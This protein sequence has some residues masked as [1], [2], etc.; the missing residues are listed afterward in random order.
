MSFILTQPSA[1]IN[2]KLTNKGRELLAQGA[3]TYDLFVFGD[4]EIDYSFG[5]GSYSPTNNKILAPKDNNPKIKYPISA[6]RNSNNIFNVLPPITPVEQNVVNTA[7]SRGFFTGITTANTSVFSAV[8]S[9]R[10]MVNPDGRIL[11]KDLSGGTTLKIL[12]ASTYSS[13]N[14]T[15]PRVGDYLFVGIRHPYMF[16]T[17][18][19]L[20]ATTDYKIFSAQTKGLIRTGET[21]PYLFY[22]IHSITSGSLSSGTLTVVVD[23]TL[24]NFSSQTTSSIFS[25][26]YFFPFT[27]GDSI[28]NFYGSGDTTS[29]WNNNTLSFESNCNVAN[30]DVLVWNM[31]IVSTEN[32]AGVNTSTYEGIVNYGSSAY[33][34]F[35][36]YISETS[37]KPEQFML[38]II[39]YT[40][41]SISNYYAEGFN[42]N[43]LRLTLPTI[44]WH[45][46]FGS[47][48]ALGNSIGLTLTS[49]TAFTTSF[50]S[51]TSTTIVT[52]VS[53]NDFVLPFNNL[54]D[55]N[56]NIV[57][58]IFNDLKMVV[59]EDQEL[60]AAMSYKS[61]RN[62]TLPTLEG[63]SIAATNSNN[64]LSVSTPDLYVTYLLSCESI[65]TGSY[66]TP[67]HC[68]NYTK[69]TRGGS[70]LDVV[71][72]NFPTN[73]LPYMR[74]TLTAATSAI[75]GG[76]V[77]N[78]LY[79]LAQK[80][81]SGV[82]PDSS[83]WKIMDY[84]SAI[85][86]YATWSATTINPTDIDTS[87]FTITNNEYTA[88]TTYNLNTYLTIPTTGQDSNLQFG[89][90][91]VFFGNLD[92]D[93][94]A[95]AYKSSFLFSA[96]ATQYNAS[97]NP[98]YS[99]ATSNSVFLSEV[100]VYN[101]NKDLVAIGKFNSPIEKKSSKTVIVELTI[102]F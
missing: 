64:L 80:T 84:T 8:T 31:N 90:E 37:D 70:N 79:I 98:T 42:A 47:T 53:G 45:D 60:L 10:F 97:Y 14:T 44:L 96:P 2:A 24:P 77:A 25:L 57:G 18:S 72:V 58:K 28:N 54:I 82:R 51:I 55:N 12:S 68:L 52:G 99:A 100:G 94:K 61:N 32:M 48:T 95:T 71:K 74:A 16:N 40:N 35:K 43:T 101:T 81:A 76:F 17:I 6:L 49:S 20:T 38:G 22:K 19:G 33:T 39:H 13:G 91:V 86:N 88:A 65:G 41:H 83:A 69:V 87:T 1:F 34:G 73:Q 29:Y 62:W 36:Q 23:R 5:V 66:S 93:I 46:N 85:T 89:D 21:V 4:S 92:A 7:K 78:K 63:S 50:T 3:L 15:E 27:S 30:D 67:L 59:I 9:N 75:T 102:D 56:D 11:S 26:A